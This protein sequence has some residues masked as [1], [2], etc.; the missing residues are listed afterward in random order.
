MKVTVFKNFSEPSENLPLLSILEQIRDGSFRDEVES[1]R[2]LI[3][4]EQKKEYSQQKKKLPAFTPSGIFDGGR[5]LE[6]L[7]SYSGIIVLDID[8]VDSVDLPS[9]KSIASEILCTYAC[10]ISPSNCG[11]KILVR[12]DSRQA[13]H[14][15]A[16][17][18]VKEYYEALLKL[19][20]DR[21]GKDITRLCFFSFD[22]TIYINTY[23]EIFKTKIAMIE[24]DIK[25]VV[26]LIESKRLDIT[27]SY[28]DWL[29]IGFAL[30]D[31]LGEGARD[32]FHKISKIYIDYDFKECDRQFD[33][34]LASKN[35]GITYKT[36]FFLARESGIDISGLQSDFDFSDY[37]KPVLKSESKVQS[38][39]LPKNLINDI[40]KFLSKKYDFRINKVTD[41]LEFRLLSDKYYKSLTDYREN[42]LLR[43]MLSNNIKCNSTQLHNLLYSDFSRE[44]DPFSEYFVNLEPW[45]DKT[46]Y[47]FMLSSTVKTTNEEF[48]HTS[49]KK[50]LVAAVASVLNSSI[51]NH[52]VIILS[53][54][55]GIGKTTWL[56]NLCP[57]Q[58]RNYMFSGTINPNNK[59]TLSH[60]SEC[61]LIN[62]DELENMNRADIG[63]LKNIITEQVI[64]IRK[65]YARNNEVYV[66]RAS[67]M[68]SVNSLEFLNDSTGSRRFLC[69]EVTSINY[70]HG[71][72]MANVYSQALALYLDGYN[73]FFAGEEIEKINQNNQQ[74]QIHTAEEELLLTHFKPCTVKDATHYLTATQ[75]CSYIADRNK[76]TINTSTSICMGKA[77]RKSGFIRIKRKNIYVW[78]LI[79]ITGI[80]IEANS[81]K[82]NDN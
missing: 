53:G 45:D 63:T 10:F 36:F 82:P 33:K 23:S 6:F 55:Q 79:E 1:L 39:K 51:T 37:Q 12:V 68:G 78:A 25:T 8:K 4:N 81:Q 35:S 67:F 42:S 14:K 77:L 74:F 71:I 13:Y 27:N 58:L 52:Q 62:M 46:D 72:D 80:E 73:H 44:Y 49:F 17:E 48:W 31:A 70:N 9:L 15:Q 5:K 76:F 30:I 61:I 24:K 22:E 21:T 32:Y 54:P 65:P 38:K 26:E 75:V 60:L 19:S 47:I 18:Q 20:V 29:K 57:P 50:W 11:L 40:E 64:R 59:D 66:R 3:K 7:K 41:R 2:T 69:F 16:F 28:E 43:E 56:L 34:C